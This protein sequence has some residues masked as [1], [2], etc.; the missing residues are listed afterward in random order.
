M[1]T[2]AASVMVAVGIL[3][4]GCTVVGIRAVEEARYDVV[5]SEGDFEVRDYKGAVIA[6]TVVNEEYEDAGGTGFRRLA[7]YI[8]G[9]N[10]KK[11]KI[12]MTAPVIQEHIGEN[13]AMTAPVVREGTEK[14]WRM[15]FVMPAEYSLETLPEPLDPNVVLKK[16]PARR[17]ATL[18]YRGSLTEISIETHTD[19]L[20]E[21]LKKKSLKA[22]S[23]PRSAG[24]DPP[25]TVPMLRRNEVH[26]EVET[27]EK[28]GED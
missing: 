6:E 28:G 9:K 3:N 26:V 23:P 17:V 16:V 1:N 24:Y 21:W 20:M 14:G 2:K 4:A 18:R 15:A 11:T 10:R 8:F 19:R 7:G 12:A 13:I 27:M 25:W 22:V 5:V